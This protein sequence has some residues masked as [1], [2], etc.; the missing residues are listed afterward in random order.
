[1]IPPCTYTRKRKRRGTR[2]AKLVRAPTLHLASAPKTTG[3]VATSTHRREG[4]KGRRRL[5]VV[6]ITPALHIT[7]RCSHAVMVIPSAK[8]NALNVGT[9][10]GVIAII[11]RCYSITVRIVRRICRVCIPVIAIGGGRNPIFVTVIDYRNSRV[12]I[13]TILV[14]K[15]HVAVRIQGDIT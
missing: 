9:R 12:I 6:I 13:I 3:V 14:Q 8:N 15:Y 1:V 5:L 10:I 2:L 4:S 7:H 11:S